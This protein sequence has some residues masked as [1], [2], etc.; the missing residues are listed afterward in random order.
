M[1]QMGQQQ[2][3]SLPEDEDNRISAIMTYPIRARYN[4]NNSS[5][6]SSCIE[7]KPTETPISSR[8][9]AA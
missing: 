5:K 2:P 1:P 7:T 9:A 6:C 3:T 4:N 8:L